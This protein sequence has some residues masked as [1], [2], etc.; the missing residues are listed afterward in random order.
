MSDSLRPHGLQ[1]T[2]LPCPS[3]SPRVCSNSWPLSRWYHP[4]ISFSVTPF[5]FCLQSFP[6]SGSFQWISSTYQVAKVLELQLQH[7]SFQWIFKVDF[8]YDWQVWS[9]CSPRDPPESSLAPQYESISSSPKSK[10][11]MHLSKAI[12]ISICLSTSSAFYIASIFEN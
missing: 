12:M 1:H 7:H 11:N 8:L 10:E 9:P 3:L 2:R 4:N 5:D 6:A